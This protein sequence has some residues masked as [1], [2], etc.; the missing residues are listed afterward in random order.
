M[1]SI[2]CVYGLL[3]QTHLQSL[4]IISEQKVDMEDASPVCVS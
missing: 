3:L 2:Q 4:E 1:P